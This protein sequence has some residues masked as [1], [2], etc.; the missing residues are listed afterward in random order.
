MLSFHDRLPNPVQKVGENQVVKT[1]TALVESIL[2]IF[3]PKIWEDKNLRW[4]NPVSK[5]GVFEL[6][7][8]ARLMKGLAIAIPDWEERRTWIIKEMIWSLCP[9]KACELFVRRNYLGKVWDDMAGFMTL[10]GN[11]QQRDF[12]TA[13]LGKSGEVM[14]KKDANG[15]EKYV[16]FD[17][18]VGNPPYQ[19]SAKNDR[20]DPKNIYPDFVL[21]AMALNPEYMSMVIPARWMSG[22]GKGIAKFLQTMIGGKKI[23]KIISTENSKVWF[24]DVDIK[25]GTCYFLYDDKHKSSI[26]NVNSVDIDL[27]DQDTISTDIIGLS[28][29]NKVLAACK[30]TFNKTILGTNP[31]GVASNHSDW[32]SDANNS[33]ICHCSGG[34]GKGDKTNL[35]SKHLISRNIDSVAKYK[36]CVATAYGKGSD[37]LG[38]P[39]IIVPNHIVSQSYAVVFTSLAKVEAENAMQFLSSKIAQYLVSLVKKTQD[40]SKRVFRYLPYLDFTRSYTDQD[41]YTIFDLTKEEIEHVENTTKYFPIFKTKGK[42]SSFKYEVYS[43]T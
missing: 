39:F 36:V 34:M 20:S 12:L 14:V 13:K 3:P 10:E 30:N 24:P 2:D 17:C 9:T 38:E 42:E 32:S 43:N 23:A 28:I 26:T 8:Y 7:I 4:I 22:S 15:K 27:E 16:K 1:P 25:G 21:K 33:Y 35:L 40:N 29:K 37:G 6:G 18:V 5:T 41:L 19:D 31:F 11:V